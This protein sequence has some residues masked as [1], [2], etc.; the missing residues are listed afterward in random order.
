MPRSSTRAEFGSRATARS[1]G[2]G[3]QI[4][5]RSDGQA[6]VAQPSGLADLLVRPGKDV[7][8]I[9]LGDLRQPIAKHHLGRLGGTA[10]YLPNY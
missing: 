5:K 4:A 9:A 1:V 8:D 6:L 2:L 3:C 7:D 10:A